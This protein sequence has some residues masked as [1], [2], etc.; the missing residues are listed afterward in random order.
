[1]LDRTED[2]EP[3]SYLHGYGQLVPG[4]E[5]A[6]EGMMPGDERSVVVPPEEG[7][8]DYDPEAV[9]EIER[10]DFPSPGEIVVGDQFIAESDDGENVPMTVLEVTEDGCLVDTNHPLAGETLQVHQ[11]RC[12][13]CG[14]PPTPSFARPSARSR[15][16]PELIPSVES[17]PS[18]GKA[19]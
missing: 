15:P 19:S 11:S 18:P 9:L 7:Y 14:P 3:L 8:G 5:R 6:I 10:A 2:E 12:S 17:H 4:L 13:R 1:M 16:E